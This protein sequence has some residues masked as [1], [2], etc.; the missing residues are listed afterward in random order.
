MAELKEPTLPVSPG[1][2]ELSTELAVPE[3][4]ERLV[5]FSHPFR[6]TDS[7]SDRRIAE[8]LQERGLATLRV[9]V[10]TDREGDLQEN[11]TDW[12]LLASRL[13]A[14][15]EW[16]REHEPTRGLEIGLFG[17]S[18]GAAPL[19][20][21]ATNLDYVDKAVTRGGS[22]DQVPSALDRISNLLLIVGTDDEPFV[23][24]NKQAMDR[25]GDRGE[26]C[27]LEGAG[28]TD[29]TDEQYGTICDRTAAW[30]DDP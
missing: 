1:T 3:S 11:T 18:A 22:V 25:L 8:G 29:F 12:Q 17:T 4:A 24:I 2:V 27:L 20:I 7:P 9:D 19:L 16:A 26:I 5:V 13:M 21:A 23:S 6:G 28:H 10:L 14:V 30:F 15:T